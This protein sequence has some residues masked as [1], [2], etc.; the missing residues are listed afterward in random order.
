MG[1]PSNG[2]LM[3]SVDVCSTTIPLTP[4][5]GKGVTCSPETARAPGEQPV[6]ASGVVMGEGH[7]WTQT[8][9]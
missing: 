3:A 2:A 8:R 4:C 9:V 5:P 7:T 6:Y 1:V